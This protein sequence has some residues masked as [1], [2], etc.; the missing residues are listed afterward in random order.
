[1][2]V[3]ALV[4][5]RNASKIFSTINIE[6][7]RADLDE[8]DSLNLRTI[9][10]DG[11]YYFVPPQKTGRQDQRIRSFLSQL[12]SSPKKFVLISTTGVYGDCDGAWVDESYP[13]NP[14]NDRARRRLDMEDV[15]KSWCEARGVPWVILRVS[16]IYGPQRLPLSRLQAGSP[17]LSAMDCGY[18]NRIHVDD[19]VE[20]CIKAMER[21]D[22]GGI[23]NISDGHPG[24]MREYF[25]CVAKKLGLPILPTV[26]KK[27]AAKYFSSEMLSYL[28]E[29]R[30][31][32]N[33]KMMRILG[34]P[35][36]YPDLQSGLKEVTS[37]TLEL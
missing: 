21:I 35:L 6:P 33:S 11:I 25:D 19:L 13:V 29:S 7:V 18:T 36:R 32:D 2:E 12:R 28:N 4:T 24:T 15:L 30:R 1:M 22:A 23:V 5:P 14:G 9:D 37:D 27:Q 17:M 34:R 3:S 31:I 10:A 8:L 16:G 20:I 26:S